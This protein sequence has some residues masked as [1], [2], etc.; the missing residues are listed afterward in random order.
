MSS[1]RA[2]LLEAPIAGDGTFARLLELTGNLL[3]VLDSGGLVRAATGARGMFGHPAAD[4]VGENLFERIHPDDVVAARARILALTTDAPPLRFEHRCRRNDGTY[5]W[6]AW[7]V[8]RDDARSLSVVLRD[9]TE[10]KWV[11]H[12]VQ[13]S[14]SLVEAT[15]ESTADGL[16]VADKSGRIVTFN[17]KFL[18]LWGIPDSVVFSGSDEIDGFCEPRLAPDEDHLT[19]ARE[20]DEAEDVER[21]EI[22]SLRDGRVL[23]RYSRP[24][25]TGDVIEGRVW[26]FRDVTERV[27]AEHELHEH[28]NM[29]IEHA[30]EGIV[31]LDARGRY[32]SIN[33]VF[34]RMIGYEAAELLGK[35][36]GWLCHP[37][38]RA[39][40]HAARAKMAEA[41]KEE[42]ELRA[43]R[44]DGSVIVLR[45]L[46]VR[47]AG[48]D[49]GYYGFVS[50]ITEKKSLEQRLLTTDRMTSMG[51]LAAGV[52]HEINNPLSFVITNTSVLDDALRDPA[53]G[54]D[55]GRL[56][57]LKAIVSDIRDGAERVRRIVRDLKMFSRPDDTANGAIDVRRVLESSLSMAWNEI[58]HRARLVK[59]YGD[60]A[61]VEANDGQL[62]QVFLNLLINAAHAIPEGDADN[63]E[64]RVATSTDRDGRVVI[65]IRDTGSGIPEDIVP[66]IFDPFFTTKPVGVGTGLGLSVCH[67][68]VAKL[69]GEITVKSRVGEGTSFRVVLRPAVA[70][71]KAAPALSKVTPRA[72]RRDRILV[73]DDEAMIGTS[74][75]RFLSRHHYDVAVCTDGREALALLAQPS[76]FELVLCDVM[77]PRFSGMDVYEALMQVSPAIARRMVFMTGGVFTPRAKAFLDQVPNHRLDKPVDMDRLLEWMRDT[78][79]PVGG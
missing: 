35:E 78:L 38:D 46:L 20:L 70:G 75:Q 37:E 59:D 40:L 8:A 13:A 74:I 4:I 31:R 30:V 56:A 77:M 71:V 18:E 5:R 67:G 79:H 55:E 7:C 60:V 69:G 19:M 57:E 17:R 72:E 24:R 42:M 64:I 66:R 76:S 12:E 15:L 63:N 26:S 6:I 51:T 11:E 9:V 61:M 33:A 39:R 65:E 49:A 52:A 3:C 23:E 44:K 68:I 28:L 25:R 54:L 62:G 21:Y 22:L 41:G 14:L 53:D 27:R 45:A 73:V 36:A 29:G 43:V 48:G 47:A 1:N 34:A 50:D 10:R 16:L 32:A 2:T 58:R